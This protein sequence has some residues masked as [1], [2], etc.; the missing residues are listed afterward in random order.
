M[1]LAN[2]EV[3]LRFE[4]RIR[5]DWT[6]EVESHIAAIARLPR[7]CKSPSLTWYKMGLE[8]NSKAQGKR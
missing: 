3:E 7:N 5:F 1:E 2:E 8:T 4:W 6:G